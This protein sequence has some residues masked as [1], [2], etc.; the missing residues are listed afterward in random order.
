MGVRSQ[1]VHKEYM[2][3]NLGQGINAHSLGLG[4]LVVVVAMYTSI[5]F[6]FNTCY[7]ENELSFKY[8]NC[9]HPQQPWAKCSTAH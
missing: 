2:P 7:A 4:W 6:L 3:R 1:R 5:K 8:S 9:A